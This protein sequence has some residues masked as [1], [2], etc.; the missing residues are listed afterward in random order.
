MGVTLGLTWRKELSLKVSEKRSEEVFV[1][2]WNEVTRDWR[3]LRNEKL[4]DL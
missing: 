2:K 3:K 1:P 4:N